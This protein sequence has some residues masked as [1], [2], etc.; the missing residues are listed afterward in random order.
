MASHRQAN[1]AA[2]TPRRLVNAFLAA[3]LVCVLALIAVESSTIWTRS[4][5]KAH[6]PEREVPRLN[7]STPP[8]TAPEGMV[9]VPGGEFWMGSDSGQ[10]GD[11]KPVH[12]VYVDGFWMD[13]T[14]VTNA[15]FAKFV[16]AAKY[17]TVAERKPEAKD[18]PD[19]APEDL[20]PFSAV[21]VN[22]PAP[23]PLDNP[24]RWWKRVPG[25]NWRHPAGPD[26]S[27]SKDY[28]A[29]HI[30]W[31][32]AAAYAKWAG[33]RL[34]T[35]AE[36]EFAARG[37]LDRQR[38]AWGNEL[39]PGGKWMA[40]IWQG[41][42]PDHNSAEDGFR[43]VAPVASFP[44]NGYGLHDMSGNVWEWCADWYQPD[45]YGRSPYRNP[46]GPTSGAPD[47]VDPRG[48]PQRVR[49][50]GSYLC[51]DQYCLRYLPSARDKNPPESSASH[52]GFRCVLS[53]ATSK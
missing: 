38:F 16:E 43:G 34:P 20:V 29:V 47:E 6:P 30:A 9:W 15:Q 8:G 49:R 46:P 7:P 50:G 51:S 24:L 42:F 45:Y 2:A 26:S 23:V 40:N 37:G 14:E 4:P 44:P 52:T 17:V 10:D 13:R 5:Q 36:W 19:A 53:P 28:P 39:T 32:D 31:E 35:E 21:F 33:K 48:A 1:N 12:K 11:E 22:S 18:F 25:A 3:A 41:H 27:I